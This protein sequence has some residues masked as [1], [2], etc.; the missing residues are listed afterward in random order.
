VLKKKLSAKQ[1][2]SKLDMRRFMRRTNWA[3]LWDDFY[4]A[5]DPSGL[6]KYK[7]IRRFAGEK[8][9]SAEE[10]RFMMYYLGPADVDLEDAER[11]PWCKPQD[12]KK[13]RETTGWY[14]DDN[15]TALSKAISSKMNALEA[16]AE[17]GNSVTLRAFVRVSNLMHQL[18][19]AF[20]G[21]FFVEG[22][23]F[24]ANIQRSEAYLRLYSRVL[25]MIGT[26]QDLYAKSRG[27]N[28][29]DMEG[30]AHILQATAQMAKQVGDT[31][32]KYD[33]ALGAL[34][35]MTIMKSAEY[36]LPLPDDV[37]EKLI[38]ITQDRPNPKKKV[39]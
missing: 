27:I 2:K 36:D 33:K 19:N 14:T 22:Q 37:K 23:D 38:D 35:Q 3:D 12:W 20:Q 32:S 16:L 10:I 30:L 4:M 7:T 17:A 34:M 28:F 1:I 6:P 29:D 25:G 21:R 26:A 24:A 18:D 8:G 11:Y 39:N 13:R 9:K 15:I 31:G 5:L